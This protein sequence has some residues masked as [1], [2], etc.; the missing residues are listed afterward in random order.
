MWERV[1]L[2]AWGLNRPSARTGHTMSTVGHFIYMYGGQTGS[3]RPLYGLSGVDY[4]SELWRFDTV[5]HVWLL[6]SPASAAPEGRACHA[7]VTIGPH[8]YVHGGQ[9]APAN[10][11]MSGDE[12][13]WRLSDQVWRLNAYSREWLLLNVST[14]PSA[15]MCHGMAAVGTAIYLTAGITLGANGK[16]APV[17][18]LWKIPTPAVKIYA[19]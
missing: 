18:D 10:G 11:S 4:S 16:S 1:N 19:N 6:L 17:S 2:E 8:I 7:A 13:S 9:N 14:A 12:G 5:K 3:L 15:R